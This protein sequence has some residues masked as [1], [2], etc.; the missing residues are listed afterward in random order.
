M[1]PMV[2]PAALAEVNPTKVYTRDQA[3][4]LD[5]NKTSDHAT[6]YTLNHQLCLGYCHRPAAR[7]S[8]VL[9]CCVVCTHRG[10]AMGMCYEIL[11]FIKVVP[12]L[13]M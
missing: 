7:L 5:H 10:M 6:F 4:D 9:L 13:A 12:A 11:R 2:Y 3:C 8:A 1:K